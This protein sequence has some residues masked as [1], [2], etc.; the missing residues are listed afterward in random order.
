LLRRGVHD[1]AKDSRKGNQEERALAESTWKQMS[2]SMQEINPLIGSKPKRFVLWLLFLF[3]SFEGGG[4]G[5]SFTK[6]IGLV[7][8]HKALQ[9]LFLPFSIFLVP[10]LP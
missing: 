2:K 9:L 6:S 8:I 3:F 5:Y 1:F 4:G 10:H 7:G